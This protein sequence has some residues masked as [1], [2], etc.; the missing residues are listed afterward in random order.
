MRGDAVAGDVLHR[1]GA[2]LKLDALTAGA[3]NGG[4]DRLIVVLLR[5]RDV[6]L[7]AARHDRPFGVDDADDAIAVLDIFNDD[8]KPENIGQLLEGDRF[9]LHLAPH[10]IGML[11]AA[12]DLRFDA[13]RGEF[14]GEFLLD[15]CDDLAV[16]AAKLLKPRLDHLIGLRHQM[17]EGEIL[18]FVA[19]ALH[20]H[21]PRK[22]RVD[23]ECLLGDAGAASPAH[24]MQRAHIVQPVGELD[25]ENADIGCDGEQELAEIFRMRGA[26]GDKI[27]L[28]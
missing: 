18:Q 14:V 13:P 4:V 17:P 1:L 16:L 11:L 25:E 6:I 27:E 8:A 23:I 12:L 5:R 2:H 9:A 22:R 21:A 28:L 15:L 24:E 3:D 26:L 7:E 20:A 19:H 10:G